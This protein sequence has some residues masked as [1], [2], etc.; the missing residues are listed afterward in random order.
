MSR[1]T[2]ASIVTLCAV[3]LVLTVPVPTAPPAMEA[4]PPPT[5]TKPSLTSIANL[6]V[7]S[8]PGLNYRVLG[9]LPVGHSA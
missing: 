8:G 5:T 4:A 9:L 3:T 1:N 7:R 6:N 2:I